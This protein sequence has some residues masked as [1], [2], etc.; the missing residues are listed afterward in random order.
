MSKP[1]MKPGEAIAWIATRNRDIAEACANENI[2]NTRLRIVDSLIPG[3]GSIGPDGRVNRRSVIFPVR[4][5]AEQLASVCRDN[6]VA[7]EAIPGTRTE[8]TG[9]RK[10]MTSA[11]G[12]TS[13]CVTMGLVA[14][15]WRSP[16]HDRHQMYIG[17]TFFSVARTC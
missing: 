13:A 8:T 17:E 16:F 9:E 15:S 14:L 3:P 6:N 4:V 1:W 2:Q 5:A 10:A 7:A 12:K 11:T